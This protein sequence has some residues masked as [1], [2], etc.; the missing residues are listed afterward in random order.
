MIF[1]EHQKKG[2]LPG[3]ILL[4]A[5]CCIGA[6]MLGLPVSTAEA[7]FWPSTIMFF[8]A[9]IFMMSTG[10]L[11][12]EVNL[13]FHKE[14]NLITMAHKTLGNAGR[15]AAWFLFV[16]LFYSIMVSYS[17]GGG[18]LFAD[19]IELTFG[20]PVSR[21]V[22]SVVFVGFFGLIIYYGTFAVDR[23]NRF[24][25]AG[26]I[27]TFFLL[28][29]L[30]LPHVR[31][32]LYSYYNPIQ[33]IWALPV[34]IVSFGY[35]NLIPSLTT[36]LKFDPKRMRKAIIFGSAIPLICNVLWERLILGLISPESFAASS[37]KGT[38]VT[39]AL[40]EASANVFVT[41]IAGYFAFFAIITSFIGV[42]LSFVDFL[43]DGFNLK[44]DRQSKLISCSLVLV[45]PLVF[46]LINPDIFVT[47]LR[48]AGGFGAVILFG[49]LPCLMVLSGRYKKKLW[50]LHLL[51][52]GKPVLF[53]VMF[54]GISVF[55]IQLI[56]VIFPEL[57]YAK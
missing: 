14:V 19:L 42:A 20:F 15:A 46:A 45:P 30:G 37:D 43:A 32:E 48:Y 50:D 49:V 34:M 17:A 11:L 9:W 28:L 41:E 33:S 1:D 40:K 25:M 38:M 54:F 2:S 36:Y 3:S 5:G 4:I 18:E 35:H 39:H 7:G 55:V 56:S 12:L 31:P 44:K 51:P 47:A 13:S 22:G 24:L 27:A 29:V 21:S 6:G 52:G 23:I 53:L 8:L 26:L 57:L 10:L 16:F